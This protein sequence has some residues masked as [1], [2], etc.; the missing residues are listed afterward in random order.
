MFGKVL[1]WMG[2]VSTSYAK[3]IE[4]VLRKKER[5]PRFSSL[6]FL[7][8]WKEKLE[9]PSGNYK[10]IHVA[11]TNGKGSVC[12]KLQ[13]SL[14]KMGF[15]VG[16]FTSPHLFSFCERIQINNT[17]ISEEKVG[18][19]AKFFTEKIGEENS[20]SFFEEIFFVALLFFAKEK[21]DYVI[22]E[23]GIG[24]RLDA[25]NI[26]DPI[27]TIIT[28]IGWDHMDILGD[29]L[30]KIASEKAG[31]IKEGI[32]I[33]LG[34]T[35]RKKSCFTIAK[36]KKAPVYEVSGD[37]PIFDEEN[38]EV[39]K[40]A[41]SVLFPLTSTSVFLD[42][43]QEKPW[44]RWHRIEKE[45]KVIFLDGAHNFSGFE[46][47]RRV[48]E[49]EL[50]GKKVGLVASFSQKKEVTKSLEE[51]RS[52]IEKGYFSPLQNPRGVSLQELQEKISSLPFSKAFFPSVKEAFHKAFS[53][54][55][56]I[57]VTGSFYIMEE[58]Y[59]DLF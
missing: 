59:A 58:I 14:Q 32:P 18:A 47:L 39:V 6:D 57:L 17:P 10:S 16:L 36:E 4:R 30:E 49:K 1:G 51:I 27:L 8:F 48:L 44:G 24:G 29:S 9:I 3:W 52:F 53:S 23:A 28:S 40:K 13:A 22:W 55:E 26:I 38:Q 7:R 19:L 35:A 56:I 50:A 33:V 2:S 42:A 5:K 45:G 46:S 11:G 21:V 20:L 15:T 41:L 37:F 12:W 25:T 34:P 43:L 54:H 31:I